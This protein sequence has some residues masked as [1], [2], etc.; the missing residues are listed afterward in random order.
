M[1]DRWTINKFRYLLARKVVGRHK[2]CPRGYIQGDQ[3]LICKNR[4]NTAIL[5]G[6]L[7]VGNSGLTN[8]C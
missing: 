2:T 8:V 6:D 7:R 1:L 4:D 3:I 5:K